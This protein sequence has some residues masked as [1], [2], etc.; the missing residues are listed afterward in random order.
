MPEANELG[1]GD[2]PPALSSRQV[3]FVAPK[4]RDA[5][6]TIRGFVY[7]A[8]LTIERWLRL[9]PEQELQLE[10]GEDID[11]V[12]RYLQAGGEERLLEQVKYRD[13]NVTLKSGGVLSA[14]ANAVEHRQNNPGK[15][16]LF[17]FTTNAPAG[18][19][20]LSPF[21]G[22]IPG[23][24]AWQRLR[25]AV[26]G[27]KP[28]PGSEAE[29]EQEQFRLLLGIRQI[30]V[31]AETRPEDLNEA[32]WKR[33]RDFVN[34]ADD[35]A[36][37][38]FVGAFEW[39]VGGPAATEMSDRV[40]QILMDEGHASDPKEAFS[41][42]QRLFLHVLKMLSKREG[43]RLTPGDLPEILHQPLSEN[44]RVFFERFLGQMGLL[45]RK[46]AFLQA[47]IGQQ[48]EMLGGI[49]EQV[50][51][52]LDLGRVQTLTLNA[53]IPIFEPPPVGPN[54]S[55]RSQT[56]EHL[57]HELD[58]ITWLALTG[59]S[60]TGKSHLALLL[61]ARYGRC[62]MWLRFR[63][64]D[65]ERAAAMLD[66]VFLHLN[67]ELVPASR[68]E[69]YAAACRQFGPDALVVL[70]DLPALL[71]GDAL[72]QRLEFL[73]QACNETGVKVATT[74]VRRLPGALQRV[75]RGHVSER[76]APLL[77]DLEALEILQSFDA[78]S[79]LLSSVGKVRFLNNIARR[80]P[81]L[82]TAVALYLASEGWNWTDQQLDDLLLG[83]FA[84][85]VNEETIQRL[86]ATVTD[87]PSKN[88]LYRLNLVLGAFDLETVR[89]LAG[90]EPPV[91]EPRERLVALTG[92]WVQRDTEAEM[93]VSPL[94]ST[95]GSNDLADEVRHGCYRALAKLLLQKGTLGPS[96]IHNVITYQALAQE[97]EKAA[98]FLMWGLGELQHALRVGEISAQQA[99]KTGIP[100]LL[101]DVPIPGS[102]SLN[103]RLMLRAQQAH[104]AEPLD[105]DP[106]FALRDLAILIKEAGQPEAIGLIMAAV[107]SAMALAGTDFNASCQC[108]EKALQAWPRATLPDGSPLELPPEF[109][110]ASLVW[111]NL[112]G[113]KGKADVLRWCDMLAAVSVETRE[114]ALAD[115]DFS[116][117][118]AAV[119]MDRFWLPEGDLASED[120]NW[121]RIL[122]DLDEI[123][124][125]AEEVG[126][127]FIVAAGVRAK[128]LVLC[129]RMQ[130]PDRA[131]ALAE[132]ELARRSDN[133]R[134]CFIICDAVGRK[135]SYLSGR[136]EEAKRWLERAEAVCQRTPDAFEWE[137][138]M[139]LLALA[140]LADQSGETGE[141]MVALTKAIEVTRSSPF[142]PE[143]ALVKL[144]GELALARW[145]RGD[146]QAAFDA[147]DDAIPRLL[148]LKKDTP[149]WK[150]LFTLFG[151]TA[152]YMLTRAKFGES[153]EL[154]VGEPYLPL[155]LGNFHDM[156]E[157]LLADQHQP[158]RKLFLPVQMAELAQT[159][160]RDERVAFWADQT[161]EL[162]RESPAAATVTAVAMFSILPHLAVSGRIPELFDGVREAIFTLS[163]GSRLYQLEES[164]GQDILLRELDVEAILGGRGS[165][166]WNRAEQRVLMMTLVPLAFYLGRLSIEARGDAAL[167]HRLRQEAELAISL[168]H[169]AAAI[170][171]RG[172]DW[173]EAAR[174]IQDCYLDNPVLEK[175]VD[176]ANAYAENQKA[177]K[178]VAYVGATLQHA[179][180]LKEACRVHMAA[181]PYCLEYLVKE[182]AYRL[183]LLPF[184]ETF[185]G[186]AVH[187]RRVSF[188]PPAAVQCEFDEA[189]NSPEHLRAKRIMQ[190][191]AR[192]LGIRHEA[193][194]RNGFEQWQVLE[195]SSG[196]QGAAV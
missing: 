26:T 36:W 180:V 27:S 5:W 167:A 82:L 102:V 22:N 171:A 12:S 115:P 107:F 193:V 46:L 96:E 54:L 25:L 163:A 8:D 195:R 147:L 43:K 72:V 101:W 56:V 63:D 48:S 152:G 177:L 9:Q 143:I 65:V 148:R 182:G 33:F 29:V 168:C 7:Q 50:R 74:S 126:A 92:L 137:R 185:W 119:L 2:A 89:V 84:E 90:I 6:S 104:V 70:D 86:V 120:Q 16:L 145:K 4:N 140:R 151:H 108:I 95:L 118:G 116:V 88:L 103:T 37:L 66:S 129:E 173:R 189:S 183:L 75:A 32:T 154:E 174:L 192:G 156:K 121:G 51:R 117:Q 45:D 44:D 39:S 149:G 1:F 19:E 38:S 47:Q 57:K 139:T 134:A 49:A 35:S 64:L 172:G 13:T 187:Q 158:E 175:I 93:R 81:A 79:A 155:P 162:G 3:A 23:I 31:G 138:A 17:C 53:P 114:K 15:R 85:E 127:E 55:P 164:G 91:T 52:V 113:V 170:S 98:V 99:Q 14:L 78:P 59:G 165:E 30:L 40:Q 10:C 68:H 166:D 80:H 122:G 128:V 146:R 67:G 160:G 21:A 194:V 133:P 124:A 150:A 109:E 58:Q 184:V 169:E 196:R 130:Q 132:T 105:T 20:R 186:A 144:L 60:G 176:R 106:S 161:I 41:Q 159:V 76:E 135:L 131:I 100:G 136:E 24:S 110:P 181:F 87:A 142:T 157:G 62:P 42:Y 111:W 191:I 94:I 77:T 69:F 73:I 71:P 18:K 11:T 61:A 83:R 141:A 190:V 178:A 153:V 97:H 179:V 34:T 28:L 188:S 125:K 123:A 112:S